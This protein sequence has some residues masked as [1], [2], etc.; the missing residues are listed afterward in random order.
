M[1]TVWDRY[2]QQK[3]HCHGL[4]EAT[5]GQCE[6]EYGVLFAIERLLQGE[7]GASVHALAAVLIIEIEDD[8][9]NEHIPGFYRA[10]LASIRPQLTGPI[11]E[12]VDR[13][14]ASAKAEEDA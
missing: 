12:D 4:R 5:R 8:E 7:M 10:A 9:D 3:E 14:L 13:V 6:A 11:A 1:L 2:R